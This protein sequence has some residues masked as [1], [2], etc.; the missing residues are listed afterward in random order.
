M[1]SLCRAS[2]VWG[3]CWNLAVFFDH[4]Y[5]STREDISIVHRCQVFGRAVTRGCIVPFFAQLVLRTMAEP[6]WKDDFLESARRYGE[7]W[8][9]C[10]LSLSS[11]PFR[12]K[13]AAGSGPPWRDRCGI[14]AQRSIRV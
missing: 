12:K 1:V 9:P 2:E 7:H 5:Q 14:S 8:W 10:V 13:H 6:T 4:L 3:L 11:E